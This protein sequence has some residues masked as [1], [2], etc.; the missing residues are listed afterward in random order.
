MNTTIIISTRVKPPL[1]FR[2]RFLSFRELID[3]IGSRSSDLDVPPAV[4]AGGPLQRLSTAAFSANNPESR[5]RAAHPG[6]AAKIALCM[7]RYGTV[8]IFGEMEPRN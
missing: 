4:W 8:Y 1:F 7:N 5:S 6:T 2:A 3:F